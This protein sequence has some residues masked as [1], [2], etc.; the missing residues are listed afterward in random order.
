MNRETCE[1]NEQPNRSVL[2]L[3]LNL[4]CPGGEIKKKIKSKIKKRFVR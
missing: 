2:N 3:I 1:I 4:F